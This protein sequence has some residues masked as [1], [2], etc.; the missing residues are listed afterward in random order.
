MIIEINKNLSKVSSFC[1]LITESKVRLLT[2]FSFLA[3]KEGSKNRIKLR[4]TFYRYLYLNWFCS[5]I[6]DSDQKVS[7]TIVYPTN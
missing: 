2:K 6:K 3:M 7:A 5:I 4:T 1:D